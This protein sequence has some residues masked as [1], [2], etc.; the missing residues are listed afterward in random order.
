MQDLEENIGLEHWDISFEDTWKDQPPDEANGLS[1]ADFINLA[2]A[3]LAYDAYNNSIDFQEQYRK[4]FHREPFTTLPGRK[5][6]EAGKE[7]SKQERDDGFRKIEVYARS[8][9]ETILK[10]D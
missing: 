10:E 9:K 1:L 5:L 6:W 7:F 2:T 4:K 3:S 8:F